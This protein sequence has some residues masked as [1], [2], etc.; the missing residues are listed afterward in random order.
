MTSRRLHALLARHYIQPNAIW[1]ELL[2]RFCHYAMEIA[3]IDKRLEQRRPRYR[4]EEA[5]QTA[6][7]PSC[8]LTPN[9]RYFSLATH[10]REPLLF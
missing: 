10:P 7:S 1:G 6:N 5:R 3:A 9:R 4:Q 8:I 2:P